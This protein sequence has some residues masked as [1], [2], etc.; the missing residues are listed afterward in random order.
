MMQPYTRAGLLLPML[1]NL[2]VAAV[3]CFL[4]LLLDGWVNEFTEVSYSELQIT[5]WFWTLMK[6]ADGAVEVQVWLP[7]VAFAAA[8]FL[9]NLLLTH[10]EVQAVRIATPDRVLWEERGGRPADADAK[11]NPWSKLE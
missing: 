10:R 7:V 5:N 2:F 11:R 6:A 4:P 1:I 9:V 8:V 3:S